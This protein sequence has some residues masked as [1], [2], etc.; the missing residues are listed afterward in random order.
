LV[1]ELTNGAAS[2]IQ[3]KFLAVAQMN[4]SSD[5]V[6]AELVAIARALLAE[7]LDLLSGCR[8][9]DQI[10]ARIEPLNRQIFNPIIGFVSET[11][12]YP[13]GEIRNIYN[14]AYLDKLDRQLKRDEF[15]LN[16]FGIPKS[17]GF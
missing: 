14:K 6:R 7:N 4:D 11:D 8:R 16:R 1:T 5:P 9:L 15:R 3:D 13:L 17:G 12:D 10:S 2:R